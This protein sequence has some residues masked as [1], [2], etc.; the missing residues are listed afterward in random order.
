MVEQSHRDEMN[1]AIRAQRE[2]KAAP[3]SIA[4]D[5]PSSHEPAAEPPAAPEP[6]SLFERLRGK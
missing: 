6:K 4:P 2:R 5:P 1:A 3:R